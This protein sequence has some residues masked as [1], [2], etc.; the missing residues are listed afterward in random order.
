MPMGAEEFPP[1]K[2]NFAKSAIEKFK[3]IL[4]GAAAEFN[5]TNLI[6]L[7]IPKKERVRFGSSQPFVWGI[8]ENAKVQ[9]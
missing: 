5:F 4:C 9:Q 1:T 2:F 8:P 3:A 7:R 6:L